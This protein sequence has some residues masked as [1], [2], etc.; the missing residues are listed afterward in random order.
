MLFSAERLRVQHW[1]K[2]IVSV[3]AL[4]VV[5]VAAD[6]VA[7][8]ATSLSDIQR[9]RES[10]AQ[11][12]REVE[13]RLNDFLER[14]ADLTAQAAQIEDDAE[15]MEASITRL[16]DELDD[17]EQLVQTRIREVY[18]HGAAIDPLAVFLSS[19]DPAGALLRVETVQRMVMAEQARAELVVAARTHLAGEQS[20][21]DARRAALADA[22]DELEKLGQSLEAEFR[23]AR[24]LENTLTV[25]ERN[26][27][28]RIRRQRSVAST[29][30]AARVSAG[31]VCPLDRPRHFINSW[32]H[33]RSGGRRHRGTDIMGPLGIPVRAITDGVWV[34]Q[35]R[36]R[37][38]GIW[39]VLRGDNGDHYWY[40]HLDSHTAAN[41]ARV[42]AGQQIG[43]NGSTGNATRGAEHIH[44]E[45]HAGGTR[46]I[47]PY[48]LLRA[49]C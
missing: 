16:R 30:S 5:A 9:Q 10:A 32:G 8:A 18:K 4:L 45:V 48:H 41:G 17:L 36:G 12:R 29:G 35:R 44:F 47:N 24:E 40:M 19:P 39:G 3:A 37:S 46:P 15:A 20:R 28:D 34:H 31:M 2:F 43:T 38:A 27:R 25:Q 49:I 26:E 7:N 21:L 33:A 14:Y 1:R 11:E 23:R 13:Q 42:R 6:G 22:Q